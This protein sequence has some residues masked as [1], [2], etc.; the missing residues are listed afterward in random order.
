MLR[1][2]IKIAAIISAVTLLLA[3]AVLTVYAYFT[4]VAYVYTADGNK[5][6]AHLGMNLSLLFDKL[7]ITDDNTLVDDTT[8]LPFIQSIDA[9]GTATYYTYDKDAKWGTAQN[10]YVISDIRHLQN[11]SALQDIGYFY[12]L[13]IVENFDANGNYTANSNSKPYFLVCRNTNG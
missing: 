2:K 7:K 12:D 11:L 1:K 9:N 6:V 13:I 5:Q 3:T 4:T 8:Q 10:P